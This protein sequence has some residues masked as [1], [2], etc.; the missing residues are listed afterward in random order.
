MI[1]WTGP[2][3]GKLRKALLKTYPEIWR[4]RQFVRDNLEH[5][6]V[7]IGGNSPAEWAGNLLEEAASVGWIDELYQ[8]FCVVCE[9]RDLIRQLRQDLGDPS[10]ENTIPGP[11]SSNAIVPREVEEELV[12][13]PRSTHLAIAVFWQE[14]SKQ[15]LR[16]HPKLYYR[17][18]KR[19]LK[20]GG[21][22]ILQESLMED[23]CSSD[24]KNFSGFLKRLVD[25]TVIKISRLFSDP[26]HGWKLTIELFVPVDLLCQPLS[27]WCGKHEDLWRDYSLVV[28]CSDRFDPDRP[29][30]ALPLHNQLKSGWQRFQQR[31]PDRPGSTLADLAWLDSDAAPTE[32]FQNYS[33]FRCYGGWLKSDRDER[34]LKNWLELVKSGIP[35]ALWMCEGKPDRAE[36]EAV[37]DDLTDSTRFEFLDRI[38]MKRD[39]Q[40]KTCDRRVGVLYEDPHYVP[41]SPLPQKEQF[42][43]WPEA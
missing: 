31:V 11:E 12:E 8:K 26:I 42:F 23:D 32:T 34:S 40:R 18:L 33:G 14:R 13:D 25:F 37:F 17:D 27:T 2:Q 28:G 21:G 16:I 29:Q 36:I 15:K 19:D 6:L 38:R 3:Q 4:L 22:D 9:N 30:D 20:R 1:E 39:E 5:S 35:V 43:V 41:D 7:G 10:P 24:L